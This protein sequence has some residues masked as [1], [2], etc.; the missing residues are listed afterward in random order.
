MNMMR[1]VERPE[2]PV[3][4]DFVRQLRTDE[5]LADAALE[6]LAAAP[7]R[8]TLLDRIGWF[9]NLPLARKIN[10]V[11]G[12]FLAVAPHAGQNDG[13]HPTAKLSHET[14][15]HRINRRAAIVFLFVLV[16]L[17]SQSGGRHRKVHMMVAWR[18]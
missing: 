11:F 14:A 8:A 5:G 18:D 4:P 10:A 2:E 13:Q 16:Q 7:G 15:K 9:R 6:G 1:V 3:V 12:T 17:D